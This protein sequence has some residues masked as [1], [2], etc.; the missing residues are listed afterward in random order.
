MNTKILFNRN[1]L[2]A[3]FET[4]SDKVIVICAK[5]R[6]YG[7]FR[8][9]TTSKEMSC[10]ATNGIVCILHSPEGMVVYASS[11]REYLFF[12]R[13]FV[14]AH[15]YGKGDAPGVLTVKNVKTLIRVKKR[16]IFS[17]IR[18]FFRKPQAWDYDMKV[19]FVDL[20]ACDY[21]NMRVFKFKAEG[22]LLHF[23]I[24]TL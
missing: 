14:A 15:E 3:Q 7:T 23:G 11:T 13:A 10:S 9:C 18:S 16:T 17:R 24:S 6:G 5:S 22:I 2:P 19:S 20:P 21:L 4:S 8:M 1:M 12:C